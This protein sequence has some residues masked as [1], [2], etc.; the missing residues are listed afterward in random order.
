MAIY[1]RGDVYWYSF[2]FA[3]QRVQESS[4]SK[5]KTVAKESEKQRRRE[6]ERGLNGLESTRETR[7][8][9]VADVAAEYLE[10]YRLRHRGVKFAEYALKHISR[11]LGERMV[12]EI[13]EASVKDYQSN[14][15]REAA[16]PKTINDEV[17]F[18][19]RILGEAGDV[20]RVRLKKNKALKLSVPPT[21]GK[22]YSHDEKQG[23]TDGAAKARSPHI[24]FALCLALNA[25]MRDSEIK[26]ITW[27]QI[28]TAKGVITVGRAKT[29][30]GEGRTIPI[31]ETIQTALA[32]HR[33]RY[34]KKFGEP[35]ADWYVFP[36]GRPTP[37]DPTRHVTTLKTAWGNVRKAAK[38]TGRWHDARHTLITELA[39]TGAGDQAIMDIAGH[40]SKQM[41]ARYSHIRMQAKRDALQKVAEKNLEN[42]RRSEQQVN[43]NTHTPPD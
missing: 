9:T 31:G 14:R 37:S 24:E 28:N 12:V 34:V 26:R 13:G 8:R 25:G 27:G 32:R 4:K 16:A 30:A 23:L 5:S 33:E 21:T 42:S 20:L 6:L 38:V 10:D 18:L 43:P 40:V 22:P 11:L 29:A 35:R 19:I 1:K 36:F 17:G 3:G 2:I 39:E 15:L 41:L 7:I